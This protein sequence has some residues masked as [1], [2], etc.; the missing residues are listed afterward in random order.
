MRVGP[1][2]R[3]IHRTPQNIRQQ[4]PL[5]V[6]LTSSSEAISDL[7]HSR[8]T[9]EDAG[10][11][12]RLGTATTATAPA[13]RRVFA[14]LAGNS[15]RQVPAT[16]NSSS[17]GTPPP[18][19]TPL[20]AA[21]PDSDSE[22][23]GYDGY[24]DID[25]YLDTQMIMLPP[26]PPRRRVP[27]SESESDLLLDSGVFSP[28]ATTTAAAATTTS[29][30]P[31][32]SQSTETTQGSDSNDGSS[33]A[34]AR[35]ALQRYSQTTQQRF[36][37]RQRG[38]WAASTSASPPAT[39][40]VS[41][42]SAAAQPGGGAS[43]WIRFRMGADVLPSAT[44]GGQHEDTANTVESAGGS[45]GVR[46][47]TP[48]DT[49][50]TSDHVSASQ[51]QH[52]HQHQHQH[53]PSNDVD[54]YWYNQPAA[55]DD[56]DWI[57]RQQQSGAPLLPVQRNAIVAFEETQRYAMLEVLRAHRT[58][59]SGNNSDDSDG[60]MRGFSPA[61]SR[62]ANSEHSAS[63][64]VEDLRRQLEFFRS[65]LTQRSTQQQS[66]L[67]AAIAETTDAMRT[68][69]KPEAA[70]DDTGAAAQQQQ[71][72]GGRQA[73]SARTLIEERLVKWLTRNTV[74]VRD[75]SCALL[76]PGMRFRGV[77]KITP[78]RRGGGAGGG[79]RA[80][81]VADIEQW[82]VDVVVQTVDM[83]RGLVAGLMRAIDVPW[84]PKAVT[85]SWEGEVVDF[86]NHSPVTGKWRASAAD[87]QQH[88][89]LFAS[90]RDHP[91]TF[92]QRWPA[93]LWG[94]RMPRVLEEYVFMRW[95]ET[96]FVNVQQNETGLSIEGFY[97]IC[98]QR[99]TGRIEGVYFD[100]STQPHQ[101]LSLQAENGGRCLA[102]AATGCC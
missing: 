80:M 10:N 16:I 29:Q 66:W 39:P 55:Q 51:Y 35:R 96:A 65:R 47:L 88:W 94:R 53:F 21:A 15:P 74:R 54:S 84:M 89:S 92:L 13:R 34:E 1:E 45:G 9:A 70:A 52:Q 90:V 7:R 37:S 4:T 63:I 44:H 58:F 5:L 100:P 87:D 40:V 67:T 25:Q 85:T 61:W 68:A 72:A 6:P 38:Q 46:R 48:Q 18:L 77:Q 31:L 73:S 14:H 11:I 20:T 23:N 101:R 19:L 17:S 83:Q 76:R 24:N 98:M 86:V 12:N 62:N 99:S 64:E 75:L 69:E 2:N 60:E 43:G 57:S 27:E 97:Y 71:A 81:L 30:L 82:E 93:R 28:D 22:S 91:E 49:T 102:F 79:R 36:L 32:L 59:G 41:S 78:A 8:T 42:S 50:T 56:S 33:E 26:T 3:R 95:K